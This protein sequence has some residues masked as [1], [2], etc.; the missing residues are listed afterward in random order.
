MTSSTI[1]YFYVYVDVYYL[2]TCRFVET[3][4]ALCV[5]SSIF[6]VELIVQKITPKLKSVECETQHMADTNMKVQIS[7]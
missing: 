6:C 4:C 2:K 1:S 5:A 3:T 7:L